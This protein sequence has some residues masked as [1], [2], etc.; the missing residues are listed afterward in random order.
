M[1]ETAALRGVSQSI[2]YVY[3]FNRLKQIDYPASPDVFYTYGGPTE[4]GNTVGNLAGRIKQVTFDG[5]SE[6]RFYDSLGNVRE[7]RTTLARISTTTGV[8]PSITF[9]MKYTYDWLGRMQTM[10]FP[11]WMDNKFSFLP[12]EG[13]LVSYF[14]DSG[15]SL[16]KVTGHHQTTNP[17]HPDHPT[18]F[19]YVSHIGYDEFHQRTVLVSGNGIA[20]IYGYEPETRRMSDI[21]ADTFGSLEQKTAFP[22]SPFHRIHYTY[23]KIG[24]ILH[25]VNNVSVQTRPDGV[26]IGPLDVTYSS[27][28]LYQITSL[29]GKYR[30]RADFGYQYSDTYTYDE[31]GNIKTKAQSEDRLIWPDKSINTS[32]PNPVVTQLAGS[33]FDHNVG[34]LTYSISNEF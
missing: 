32:D 5:G 17:I 27:D 2:K 9:N 25:M 31:L 22:P 10:T 21:K 18:D 3:D 24:N 1:G 34:E 20:N 12:G 7:A 19:T 26:F 6:Q 33:R 13:E 15:G 30:A 14:Y 29:S 28:N 11:N 23:D 4:Q 16:D 8:P